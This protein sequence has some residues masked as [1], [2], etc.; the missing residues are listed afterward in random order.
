MFLYHASIVAQQVELCIHRR[1]P[2]RPE[3]ETL[4]LIFSSDPDWFD[5][6]QPETS[7]SCCPRVASPVGF[8][9]SATLLTEQIKW[10]IKIYKYIFIHYLQS[11]VF[12]GQFFFQNSVFFFKCPLH[13]NGMSDNFIK[14]KAHHQQFS[15]L[16]SFGG[17]CW[18]GGLEPRTRRF[19][20]LKRAPA[21]L[22]AGTAGLGAKCL[23]HFFGNL[24]RPL[25]FFIQPQFWEGLDDSD[26]PEFVVWWN[27]TLPLWTAPWK[28]SDGPR[29][30]QPPLTE[31]WETHFLSPGREVGTLSDNPPTP[32]PRAGKERKDVLIIFLASHRSFLKVGE[33][34][35]V[36]A[37]RCVTGGQ[38]LH[39]LRSSRFGFTGWEV[40]KH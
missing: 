27:R 31:P 5:L 36:G 24:S 3:H 29:N 10:W 14:W 35:G 2:L 16:A 33:G 4:V 23:L 30:R 22:M 37:T 18:L 8:C 21:P 9:C 38:S 26:A 1:A 28:R 13:I 32:P 40:G 19:W 11:V 12:V 20:V 6:P 17:A 39:H 7:S 25:T 34:G 15:G